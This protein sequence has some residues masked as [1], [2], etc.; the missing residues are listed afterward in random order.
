MEKQDEQQKWLLITTSTA[1]SS[2]SLRVYVW[3]R[4]RLLG[5]VYLQQSV[6]VLPVTTYTHR[7]VNRFAD[8]IKRDGGTVR[9]VGF[10]ATDVAE[11]RRLI[12][13]FNDA[14]DIE[15]NEVLERV[16]SFL[17]ELHMERERGRTTYAEVEESEADLE[18]FSSWLNKIAKRDYF[19]APKGIEAQRAVEQCSKALAAFEEAALAMENPQDELNNVANISEVLGTL[20]AVD[21]DEDTQAKN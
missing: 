17:E 4:L 13:E 16:P 20:G 8:R 14:R 19:D 6:C 3:R 21:I 18:R 15:Y 5:A 2:A 10:Q 1:G 12:T 7:E 9:V 11:H